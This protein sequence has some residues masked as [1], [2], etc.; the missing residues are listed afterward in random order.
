LPY[1]DRSIDVVAVPWGDSARRSEARRVASAAMVE[2]AMPGIVG[3]GFRIVIERLGRH[4][5][6]ADGTTAAAHLGR[7]TPALRP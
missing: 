6:D 2:I 1:L 7:I 3:P 4:A 5:T